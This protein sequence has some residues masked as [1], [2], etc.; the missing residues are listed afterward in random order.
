MMLRT[1]RV[2]GQRLAQRG[3]PVLARQPQELHR[4]L[5]RDPSLR[6]FCQAAVGQ[7][8][9]LPDTANLAPPALAAGLCA[10]T[11]ASLVGMGGGFISIPALT[12]KWIG[13]GQHQ[14]HAAS[15]LAVFATGSFGALSFGLH[16]AV[17][18]QAAAAITAGGVLTAD[19]GASVA[20]RIPASALKI[21]LGMFMIG[22]APVV[23]YKER[24]MEEVEKLRLPVPSEDSAPQAGSPPSAEDSSFTATAVKLLFVGCGVGLLAGIFGVGGGALSVP[25]VA[26]C[27]PDLTHYQALGTSLAAMVLPAV[28]GVARHTRSGTMVF[29]AA[30][31]LAVGTAVGSFFGAQ[32]MSQIT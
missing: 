30:V 28:V 5:P 23:L 15:L 17:D 10:G 20:K 24:I 21:S 11:A 1:C 8:D 18:W 2:A 29:R 19:F 9:G 6:V 12:S 3:L 22:I 32:N 4:Q 14:A 7:G 25:A 16:G 27:L 26:I 13:L 31:P